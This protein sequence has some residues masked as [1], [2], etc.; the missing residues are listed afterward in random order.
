MHSL[1]TLWPVNWL[2][3]QHK[4]SNIRIPPPY[5]NRYFNRIINRWHL[6]MKYTL[7]QLTIISVTNCY[8]H[9]S[10]SQACMAGIV[11]AK[12]SRPKRRATT[13]LFSKNAVIS[14]TNGLMRLMFRT[15]MQTG[16]NG[17][18]MDQKFWGQE[19]NNQ[20]Y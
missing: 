9:L 5:N 3:V 6:W 13:I 2:A 1:A 4:S 18:W 7:S 11:F 16:I 19:T 12:L 20:P 8:W 14:K 10:R 17:T 15:E